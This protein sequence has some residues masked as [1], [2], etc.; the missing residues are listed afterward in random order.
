MLRKSLIAFVLVCFSL[1]IAFPRGGGGGGNNNRGQGG[2][3]SQGQGQG[4]RQWQSQN[5]S[6]Y[7]WR[8]QNNGFGQG[9]ASGQDENQSAEEN[10]ERKR[11]RATK[12]QRE[13][14]RSCDKLADGIRKQARKMAENCDKKFDQEK[15]DQ[16]HAQIRNQIRQMEMEHEQLMNG[17]DENQQ[18][19]WQEEIKTMKQLQQQLRIH[20]QQI[21]EELKS[22]PAA[23]RIAERAREMEKTMDQWRKQY[24]ILTSQT[25]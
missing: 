25:E 13:R 23:V 20:Q 10:K 7:Q 22:S 12:Q 24:G 19:A 18:Q 4:G 16:Q 3:Q 9:Q 1:A 2:G 21:D 6:Q 8:G 5:Q 11:V 17:F 15:T 14:I